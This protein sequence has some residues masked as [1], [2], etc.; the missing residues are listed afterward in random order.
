VPPLALVIVI[1]AS[2]NLQIQRKAEQQSFVFI[3]FSNNMLL[4]YTRPHPLRTFYAPQFKNHWHIRLRY[5]RLRLCFVLK[6]K[7][8]IF[9]CFL[10]IYFAPENFILPT[11]LNQENNIHFNLFI[12]GNYFVT[13]RH[14]SILTHS[15]SVRS[16]PQGATNIHRQVLNAP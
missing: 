8:D 7:A 1:R 4:P 3:L 14:P 13:K 6:L 15:L 16:Q 12:C 10:S 9:G 5:S 11:R 2:P